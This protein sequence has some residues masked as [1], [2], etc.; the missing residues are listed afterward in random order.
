MP[1][2][3]ENACPLTGLE[4]EGTELEGAAANP[5]NVDPLR[6]ELGVGGLPAKLELPLLAV[7]GPL[8]AL[9]V[10][11][12]DGDD[13]QRGLPDGALRAAYARLRSSYAASPARYLSESRIRPVSR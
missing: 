8:G 9:L 1:H 7:L 11:D 5:H 4:T 6:A 13:G 2:S 12:D 3:P 10:G